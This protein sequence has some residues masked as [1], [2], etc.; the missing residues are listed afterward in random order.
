MT[1]H[2]FYHETH[3]EIEPDM[4]AAKA[5][6]DVASHALTGAT[7]VWPDDNLSH[8]IDIIEDIRGRIA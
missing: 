5:Y 4:G 6:L 3:T 8:A 1:P 7:E 2:Q